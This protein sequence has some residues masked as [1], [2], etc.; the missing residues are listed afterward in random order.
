MSE[1]KEGAKKKVIVQFTSSPLGEGVGVSKYV[2]YALKEIENSGLKF[3]LTPMSTIIEA[4]TC[5]EALEA[6]LKTHEA[7]F[8]T[9]QPLVEK[10]QSF[11]TNVG[12]VEQDWIQ[13]ESRNHAVGLFQR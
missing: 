6:I 5:Q 11:S 9:A 4:D 12:R 7:I 10:S 2:S 3:Q 13:N 8:Q 1:K